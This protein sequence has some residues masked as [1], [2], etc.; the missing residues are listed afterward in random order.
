M[1]ETQKKEVKEEV[2]ETDPRRLLRK[3]SKA[4]WWSF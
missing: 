4:R 1:E 2:K 3:S